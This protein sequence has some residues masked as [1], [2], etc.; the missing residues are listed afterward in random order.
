VERAAQ[1]SERDLMQ[2][3]FLPGFSAAAGISNVSGGGADMDV[4]RTNVDKIGG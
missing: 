2:L 3:V 4:V 1:L